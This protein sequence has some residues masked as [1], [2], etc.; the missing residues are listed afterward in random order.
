MRLF[1]KEVELPCAALFGWGTYI[2]T[3]GVSIREQQTAK[4]WDGQSL[5]SAIA[6]PVLSMVS[7]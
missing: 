2:A 5:E 3:A 4:S 1:E 6:V 7:A